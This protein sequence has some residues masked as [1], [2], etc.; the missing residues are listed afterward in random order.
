MNNG[1]DE[2]I[3]DIQDSD[4]IIIFFNPMFQSDSNCFFLLSPAK[5]K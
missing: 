5:I 2:G 1:D 4:V 3:E